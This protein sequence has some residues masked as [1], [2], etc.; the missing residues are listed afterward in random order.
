MR[1]EENPF[2][3]SV[4]IDTLGTQVHARLLDLFLKARRGIRD[5]VEEEQRNANARK[6]ICAEGDKNPKGQLSMQG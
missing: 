5:V 2:A 6:E 3:Y 4:D 1:V